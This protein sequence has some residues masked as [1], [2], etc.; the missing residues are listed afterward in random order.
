MQTTIAERPSRLDATVSRVRAWNREQM[1]LRR[2]LY[3][4]PRHIRWTNGEFAALLGVSKGQASKI[5]TRHAAILVRERA[6]RY[7]QIGLR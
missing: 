3:Q 6:G 4:F 2:I 1:D 5:V 7:V